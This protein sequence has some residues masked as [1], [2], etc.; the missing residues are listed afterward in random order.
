MSWVSSPESLLEIWVLRKSPPQVQWVSLGVLARSPRSSQTLRSF[1]LYP[2]QALSHSPATGGSAGH[3]VCRSQMM[4]TAATNYRA[5]FPTKY[6]VPHGKHIHLTFHCLTGIVIA[7]VYKQE[8]E[9]GGSTTCLGSHSHEMQ[10]LGEPSAH[11][12]SVL[13]THQRTH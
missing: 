13:S 8:N 7:T 6:Q 2:S 1:S 9:A 5:R 10:E 3:T 4:T 12:V 11:R